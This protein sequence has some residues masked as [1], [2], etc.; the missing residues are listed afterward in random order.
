MDL[1]EYDLESARVMLRG[2]ESLNKTKSERILKD[3]EGLYL[4]IKKKIL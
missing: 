1:A 2:L 4:W 3:T